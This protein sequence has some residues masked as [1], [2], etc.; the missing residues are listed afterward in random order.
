[1][2]TMTPQEIVHELDKHIIGQARREARGGDRAAQSLAAPAGARA[3]APGDHA[4]EH[5]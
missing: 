5:I 2:S 1:M 3:A 4:E